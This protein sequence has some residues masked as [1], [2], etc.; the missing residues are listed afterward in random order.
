MKK[1][2]FA[3]A[4]IAITVSVFFG[5]CSNGPGPGGKATIEGVLK[6]T[7]YV[8]NCTT[9][10]GSFLAED[11]DVYIIYGDDPSYGD[12]VRTGPGGVFYFKYLRPGKYTI[13]AYSTTCTVAERQAVIME[14]EIT[15]KNQALVTDT[16]RIEK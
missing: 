6:A 3:I 1:S 16:L 15:D 13:Y 7:R 8:N 10:A 9:N 12:R 2:V 5:A 4:F 11:E 14:V